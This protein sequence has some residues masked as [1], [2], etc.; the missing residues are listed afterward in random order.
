MGGDGRGWDGEGDG[1]WQGIEW[2]K[3][4]GPA[5]LVQ[6]QVR[7]QVPG[8]I[9]VRIVAMRAARLCRGC[10]LDETGTEA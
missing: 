5:V 7:G 4:G 6:V 8:Q 2:G 9:Q 10:C 1:P 3:A